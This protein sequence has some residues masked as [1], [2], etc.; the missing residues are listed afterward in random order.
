[1]PQIVIPRN[2]WFAA[3]PIDIDSYTLVGCTVAPGF[4]FSDFE[5]GTQNDLAKDF[6]QHKNLITR[7]TRT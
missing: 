2:V 4:D 7:L 6:P 5:L 3:E 1:M